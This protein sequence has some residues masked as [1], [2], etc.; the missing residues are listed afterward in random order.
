MHAGCTEA[1]N[2][3]LS[4]GCRSGNGARP[5]GVW[6]IMDSLKDITP[7]D[8]FPGVAYSI[9]EDDGDEDMPYTRP[10]RPRPK[11][12]NGEVAVD[13]AAGMVQPMLSSHA[14]LPDPRV[15][16]KRSVGI[17]EL[18]LLPEVQLPLAWTLIILS[19]VCMCCRCCNGGHSEEDSG[20]GA[21]HWAGADPER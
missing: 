9:T 21:E 2:L 10:V 5:R 19:G 6:E 20:A 3:A 18:Q 4:I 11:E 12:S 13:K 8:L 16:C 15:C 7:E 1:F 17:T 14:A